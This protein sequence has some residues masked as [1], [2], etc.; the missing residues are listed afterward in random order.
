MYLILNE[1]IVVS[2]YSY[3]LKTESSNYH[4]S[5]EI[6]QFRK[7]AVECGNTADS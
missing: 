5:Q 7:Y 3:Y 6:I 4:K 2:F 1:W